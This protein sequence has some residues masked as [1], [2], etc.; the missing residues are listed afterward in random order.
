[1]SHRRPSTT[2]VLYIC[3]NHP[4]V[5]PGGAENYA[6]E[7][8][9]ALD[10]T[11]G[12]DA[13]FLAKG[14]PPVGYSGRQHAGTLIAPVGSEPNDY[15][16]YTDGYTFDWVNGTITDKDFYTHHLAKFLAA[17]RPDVIHIQHTSFIGYDLLRTIHNVLPEAVIVYTLHE[18]MPIC[19]R[20]GQ[21]LR[22]REN[23]LCSASSPR[24]CHECFPDITPQQFFMRKKFI[25]SHLSLVDR[26]ISPSRY[27]IDRF[28][29]WGI[30]R[31]R[32]TFEENG[33]TM[34]APV[35]DTERPHRDRFA[36]FGQV[37]AYKGV[38]ILLEAIRL[39]AE[40]RHVGPRSSLLPL[41]RETNGHDHADARPHL[42]VYGANLELQS[43]EHQGRI[44]SLVEVTK[45]DVTWIG[46]YEPSEL[47]ALMAG[48]DWVV[49]PSIW[50]ENSPLVIQEAFF[51]GR[52]IITS[53]IGGMA[54]KVQNGVDGLHFRA[55][56]PRD[57]AEVLRRAAT[58]PGLWAQLRAGII[59]VHTMD[60]HVARL[61]ELYDE[62][63]DAKRA[64]VFSHAR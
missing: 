64:E 35:A 15:F 48:I 45:D 9:L 39:L 40:R 22:T 5:R 10:A 6:H 46:R 56:D 16:I 19:H 30:P 13:V 21:M 33:R 14:G 61:T 4:S 62:L 17:V 32:I 47:P 58:T 44:K 53:D 26:F 31:E 29:D 36:F 18:Y 1:M 57:L 2:T 3:H 60:A 11:E 42:S 12:Y 63:M 8:F 49:V 52:P 7:L 20:D 59:P 37:S 55:R 34:L 27:L 43:S 41:L 50:W 25:Q 28:V 24:R 38:D 23:E 51:Y 54:E